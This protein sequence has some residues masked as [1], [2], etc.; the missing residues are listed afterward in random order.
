LTRLVIFDPATGT[1][2][3]V[4]SHL[5]GDN[6]VDPWSPDG[7]TLAIPVSP[8]HRGCNGHGGSVV[9]VAEPTRRGMRRIA[10]LGTTPVTWNRDGSRI[11]I[12]DRALGALRLIEPHSGKEH[13][14]PSLSPSIDGTWSKGRRLYAALTPDQTVVILDGSLQHQLQVITFVQQYAWS[15][16]RQWLAISE[17]GRIRILAADTGRTLTVIPAR[18]PHGLSVQSLAW[19]PTGRALLALAQP[20]DAPLGHD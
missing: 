11:L 19:E 3:V 15:P 12:A 20:E 14:A 4:A 13:A 17:K 1:R 8:P 7:R 16:R 5:C 18:T 2:R 6:V 10:K 9:A